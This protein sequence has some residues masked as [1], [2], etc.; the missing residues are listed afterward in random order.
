MTEQ[1]GYSIPIQQREPKKRLEVPFLTEERMQL[2]D[3]VVGQP[4]AVDSFAHLLAKVKSSIRSTEPGP[5]DTRFLAGPSGVGKTEIAETFLEILGATPDA[6][7]KLIKING[8]E[9]HERGNTATLIGAPPGYRDS[10]NPHVPGQG[11]PALLAQENLDRNAIS[12][13]DNSGK[14]RKLTVVLIDEAEKAHP[15][16]HLLLLNA[17]DKGTM[18]MANTETTD[19]S[20]TV[21]LFTSNVGN[22]EAEEERERLIRNQA[23]ETEIQQKTQQIIRD[24]FRHAFPP[25]FRGRITNIDVFRNLTKDAL[26]QI[27]DRRIQAI[28]KMFAENDVAINIELMEEARDWFTTV[29]YHPSEGARAMKKI[30]KEKVQD[31]LTLIHEDDEFRREMPEGLQRT[32][33]FIEVDSQNKENPITFSL[34]MQPIQE[35]D[36]QMQIYE[37]KK[38]GVDIEK[39]AIPAVVRQGRNPDIFDRNTRDLVLALQGEKGRK[40]SIREYDRILRA[41][42]R[43]RDISRQEAGTLPEV[44]E[45]AAAMMSQ[46]L[47]GKGL[48]PGS[49]IRYTRLRDELVSQ[50]I[51]TTSEWDRKFFGLRS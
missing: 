33:I 3:H 43:G 37:A 39:P 36:A 28:E 8:G 35:I 42:M 32:R 5:I 18:Q 44:Q 49:R 22:A 23:D 24:K 34:G 7:K 51:G 9:Y 14:E 16:V 50:G 10:V 4:E 30:I 17:L 29:G 38:T 46:R 20:N 45:A 27:V 41:L 31:P 21:F 13:N 19:F 2:T 12:Y 26:R 11:I 15:S 1:T 47:F 25:E 48:I 6:R 40:G